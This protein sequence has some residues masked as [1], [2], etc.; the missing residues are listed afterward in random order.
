MLNASSP[1]N[2]QARGLISASSY[3][4]RFAVPTPRTSIVRLILSARFWFE[5]SPEVRLKKTGRKAA[6]Y[7]KHH[8]LTVRVCL[9]KAIWKPGRKIVEKRR[10]LV[11]A[12][13]ICRTPEHWTDFHATSAAPHA[14]SFLVSTHRTTSIGQFAVSSSAFTVNCIITDRLADCKDLRTR[15]RNCPLL[16]SQKNGESAGFCLRY[17]HLPALNSFEHAFGFEDFLCGGQ[18]LGGT[19]EFDRTTKQITNNRI[20]NQL[21]VGA[22]PRKGWEEFYKL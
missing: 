2:W 9:G 10:V 8:A 22:P 3:R 4:K 13:K 12:E 7:P 1:E 17:L 21:L 19:L 20:A 5:F 11:F 6:F 18:Q 14:S 16:L 15:G